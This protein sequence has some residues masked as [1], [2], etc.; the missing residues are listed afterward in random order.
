MALASGQGS[1]LQ[2]ARQAG[3]FMKS[4][5]FVFRH[6]LSAILLWRFPEQGKLSVSL[7]EK[8]SPSPKGFKAITS[9]LRALP[10]WNSQP[11]Q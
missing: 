7:G 9:L 6:P 2:G 10:L 3:Q 1:K 8:E 4:L 11:P 5:R